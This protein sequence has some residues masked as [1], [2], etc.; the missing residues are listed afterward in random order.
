M[1]KL[2]YLLSFL[3]LKYHFF[4]PIYPSEKLILDTFLFLF[5]HFKAIVNPVGLT[6]NGFTSASPLLAASWSPYLASEVA[7][8]QHQCPS[9]SPPHGS[10]PSLSCFTPHALHLLISVSFSHGS[11]HA[12]SCLTTF[13]MLLPLRVEHCPSILQQC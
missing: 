8:V 4:P 9:L 6:S 3:S 12:P 2:L 11:C 10:Q 13:A 5:H 7:F 1:P